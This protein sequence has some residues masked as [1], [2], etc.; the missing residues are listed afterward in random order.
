MTNIIQAHKAP[1]ANLSL[2]STGTLLATASDK[3]TVIRVFSLPNGD[4]LHE[5]RRGSYPAKIYSISFNAVSTLLCVSSDTETVHI[6]KLSKGGKG[7]RGSSANG[8]EEEVGRYSSNAS[9]SEGGQKGGYEAFMDGR[10]GDAG[11]M[12]YSCTL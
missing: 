7:V 3:G 9:T 12:R 4:K 2:N 10:K 8:F 5:F 1:V 11:G 6:F